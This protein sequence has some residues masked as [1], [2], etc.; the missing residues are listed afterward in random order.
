MSK[1]VEKQIMG[2]IGI[3]Y[4]NY[5]GMGCEDY[6]CL[7]KE[8]GFDSIFTG[9][10]TMD[11]G[12]EKS[13]EKIVKAARRLNL[14]VEST[15]A[16]FDGINAIWE[17]T[18]KAQAML[19]RLKKCVDE[20]AENGIPVAVIHLSSGND[21]PCVNEAGRA[22]IEKLVDY[23]LKK[24]VKLA[25]ENLRNIANLTFVMEQY[26]NEKQIGF[27]WDTGHENCFTQGIEFMPL[28]GTKLLCTHIHD[29]MGIK[30]QDMH[31]IPFDG[32]I[33]FDRASELLSIYAEDITTTLEVFPESYKEAHYRYKGLS[34]N[35]FYTRAYNAALKIQQKKEEYLHKCNYSGRR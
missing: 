18:D 30:D 7:L 23:S 16:P 3:N 12:E 6:L 28:F 35:E 10:F 17:K 13:I 19:G 21:A 4:Y 2:K 15:H 20:C 14:E 1:R 31:L 5:A 26:K 22:N 34:I 33:N 11:E 25:F 32:N 9:H 8:T 27:C 29:N 24:G